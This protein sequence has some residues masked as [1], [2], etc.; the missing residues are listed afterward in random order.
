MRFMV[1]HSAGFW[2]F[3]DQCERAVPKSSSSNAGVQNVRAVTRACD[4]LRSF[5]KATLQTLTEVS[6]STGLDKGTTRRLLLTLMNSG[7]IVQNPETQRYGLGRL[8]RTL[9]ANVVDDFA[10]LSVVIPVL[11]EIAAE[12]HVTSFLS[13][14][15]QGTALALERLH[16]MKGIEGRW[17]P[18]GGTIPLNCG[19]APKLLLAYQTEEEITR[20]LKTP[21]Q[22]ATSETIVNRDALRRRLNLIR[23]RG[24]EFAM[25]DYVLGLTAIAAPVF[26]SRGKFVCALSITGLT[27]QMHK[28]GRPLHV[29][30]LLKATAAVQ[31]RL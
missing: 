24:W 22:A 2:R 26:D 27:P 31:E 14:Y 16:D 29:N 12:L 23:R 20:V 15:H 5:H 10:L 9:S 19:A 30:R 3:F 21:L 17:W 7:L 8:V 18:I 4:I 25:D 13:V 6:Q 1:R 11:S 28:S